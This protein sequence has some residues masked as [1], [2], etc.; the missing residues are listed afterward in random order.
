MRTRH[1]Q[2]AAVLLTG[3]SSLG[4]APAD[5]QTIDYTTA[6]RSRRIS[7][8]RGSGTIAI[9][10]RLDE[11]AWRDAPLA[12][13]FI[14]NEPHEGQPATFDTDVKVLYDDENIYFG[15]FNHDDE[16]Q[17]AIVNEL[18]KDFGVVES[19]LFG[20]VVDTFHDE[21]NGYQFEVNPK[22]ARWDAQCF[23]DSREVNSSWDGVWYVA[24]SMAEN[25]WYAEFRIPFRTVKFTN[26]SPQ[27][28]G[29]NFLRRVRRKNED[30]YWAPLPR[31]E[32][33]HKMSMAGTLEGLVG[34]QPGHNIRLKPYGAA[35]ASTVGRA[36][37]D[38]DTD[39]GVDAKVGITTGL[40]W[41]FTVNTDFSQVE[42]DEQQVNLTRFSL[43]FPEKRDFFL[44]NSGVFQFGA[45][46]SRGATAGGTGR[47]NVSRNDFVMFF[48]RRV[49]LSDAGTALPILAGTRLTGRAGAYTIGALN[50]QQRRASGVPATNVTVLRLRRNVLAN[51]DVGFIVL[52]KDLSGSDYNRAAGIDANF[53]FFRNLLVNGAVAKTLTPASRIAGT[54]KDVTLNAETSYR[55]NF[56]DLRGSYLTIGERF[57]DELGFIP[58]VGMDKLEVGVGTHIRSKR[59]PRSIR[60]IYPRWQVISVDRSDG[61]LDS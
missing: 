21:R 33:I 46:D 20:I 43:F 32:R 7:A 55:D 27:T 19:D 12:N 6:R 40:T 26:A 10:G 11:A 60:E 24:T 1:L 2:L 38:R 17:S 51:S 23:N 52:N 15:V 58:R 9:D 16:P 45:G 28:W 36:P 18:K 56:W 5:A 39:I 54:G 59:L 49:G 48:S 31:F 8:T 53:R 37:T 4:A 14:Q 30:S 61:T 47:Q 34:L 29:L 22:G 50:I 44:E 3:L 35:S 13:G 42:A 41:D 25:G 57:N